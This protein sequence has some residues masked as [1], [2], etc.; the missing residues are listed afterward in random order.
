MPK[1]GFPLLIG[2]KRFQI[3]N[4]HP[5]K[6]IFNKKNKRKKK[7]DLKPKNY[8]KKYGLQGKNYHSYVSKST[9][10]KKFFFLFYGFWGVD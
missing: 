9:L 6:H 8:F 1:N 5:K 2:K 7:H 4:L 3:L 10:Q